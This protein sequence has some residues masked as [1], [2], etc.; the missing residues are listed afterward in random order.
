MPVPNDDDDNN[1]NNESSSIGWR[2]WTGLIWLWIG[3]S[4]WFF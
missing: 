4:G 1:N 2:A 3:K